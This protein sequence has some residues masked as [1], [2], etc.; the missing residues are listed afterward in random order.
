M[1]KM[2]FEDDSLIPDHII[3]KDIFMKP[4]YQ[5]IRERSLLAPAD[6]LTSPN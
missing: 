2:D 1:D 6:A 4:G 5:I 3:D